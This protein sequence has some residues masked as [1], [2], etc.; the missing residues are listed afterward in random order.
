MDDT[1]FSVSGKR[2]HF[3][4]VIDLAGV[5]NFFKIKC[6]VGWIFGYQGQCPDTQNTVQQGS[7]QF[8]IHNAKHIEVVDLPAEYSPYP[9]YAVGTDFVADTFD[10]CDFVGN[11]QNRDK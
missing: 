2:G 8:N 5:G 4:K 1:L 11:D 6:R 3:N 9:F 7:M 10:L